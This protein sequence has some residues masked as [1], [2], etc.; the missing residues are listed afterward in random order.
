MQTLQKRLKLYFLT[1][2]FSIVFALIGFSYNVWRLQQSE[3]N[4]TIRMASF[5]VLTELAEFEQILYAAYYDKNKSVGNPRK[6][7]VKIGLIVD[8]SQLISQP[9]QQKSRLLQGSWKEHWEEITT[10]E[11]VVTQLVKELDDVRKEIKDELVQ[12]E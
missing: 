12:L 10:N 4:D 1:S 7:W 3:L 11:E 9:V 8:L 5:E 6:G 2:I